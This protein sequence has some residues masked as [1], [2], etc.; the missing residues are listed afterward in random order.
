MFAPHIVEHFVKRR[1]GG[2]V[3]PKPKG[4][5]PRL[6]PADHEHEILE[7]GGETIAD[8]LGTLMRIEYADSNGEVSERLVTVKKVTRLGGVWQLGCYCQMR[9]APRTF[10]ADRIL[11]MSRVVAHEEHVDN[12]QQW[13]GRLL[14]PDPVATLINDCRYS[15]T[16]LLFIAQCDSQFSRDE[17]ELIGEYLWEVSGY[18]SRIDPAKLR[19]EVSHRWPDADSFKLAIAG[20]KRAE[21]SRIPL[22]KRTL[23]KV[24]DSDGLLHDAEAEAAAEILAKL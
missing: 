9:H 24:T 15:L 16:L 13:L 10:R 22:F 12:V 6:P 11:S 8:L 20:M 17:I 19:A 2:A 5:V 4:F 7:P 18:S 21:S 23:K 3:V 14:D 1:P